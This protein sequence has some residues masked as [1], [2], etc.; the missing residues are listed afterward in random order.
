MKN[1][2]VI[3]ALI[4]LAHVKVIG[5]ESWISLKYPQSGLL[6]KSILK[7]YDNG[8]I[9]THPDLEIK[10]PLIVEANG[11][12]YLASCTSEL[13]K[14]YKKSAK[15]N[16]FSADRIIINKLRIR[17]IGPSEIA[18]MD[19][20]NCFI[21]EGMCAESYEVKITRKSKEPSS[22]KTLRYFLE[23]LQ[24]PSNEQ[25]A[26]IRRIE[27]LDSVEDAE[28]IIYNLKIQSS[29]VF[30]KIKVIRFQTIPL[31]DNFRYGFFFD[32]KDSRTKFNHKKVPA[33]AVVRRSEEETNTVWPGSKNRK[34]FENYL[35]KLEVKKDLGILRL[36]FSYREAKINAPWNSIE[37][38]PDVDEKGF[39]SWQL[40]D[41]Y[42]NTIYKGSYEKSVYLSVF[43][44]Q[45]SE[46]K[47]QIENYYTEGKNLI[48]LTGLKY[49]DGRIEYVT[50]INN[51]LDNMEQKIN[52]EESVDEEAP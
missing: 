44:H 35:Y 42:I 9:D 17:T 32:Y 51:C 1:T 30:F 11:P 26:L 15:D 33:P 39:K 41:K 6:G 48:R 10:E 22:K 40:Q 37:L 4:F 12:N 24:H 38:I 27:S 43:A 25:K 50:Q 19:A 14:E 36:Y 52:Q 16:G 29:D 45:I 31:Q 21:F 7:I 20:C 23:E 13:E 47:I 3:L 2:I 28:N 5:Q 8:D 34:E 18:R 46:D 49:Y